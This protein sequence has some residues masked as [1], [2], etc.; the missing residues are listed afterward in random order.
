MEAGQVAAQAKEKMSKYL[1]MANYYFTP[2]AIE[3]SCVIGPQSLNFIRELGHRL[4]RVTGEANSLHYLLQRV[5]MAIQQDN[6]ASILGSSGPTCS[7]ADN[8]SSSLFNYY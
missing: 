8:N 6:A 2:V 1:H 5:I 7:N 4:E 3:T